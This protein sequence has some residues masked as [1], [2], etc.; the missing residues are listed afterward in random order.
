MIQFN[1]SHAAQLLKKAYMM[2]QILNSHKA[3]HSYEVLFWK[4]LG[5]YR[6]SL[7]YYWG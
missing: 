5:C 3:S 2:E 7:Y 6:A 4:S 1:I